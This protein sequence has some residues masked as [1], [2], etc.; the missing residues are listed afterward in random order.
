VALIARAE[1]FGVVIPHSGTTSRLVTSNIFMIASP[2]QVEHTVVLVGQH[3]EP[4]NYCRNDAD[5]GRPAGGA[6][7]L[8]Q[9]PYERTNNRPG[10][11]AINHS[12]D[13]SPIQRVFERVYA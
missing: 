1:T 4:K 6:F 5:D 10:E 3:G 2:V 8:G 11:S 12:L 7:I 13:Q 9:E